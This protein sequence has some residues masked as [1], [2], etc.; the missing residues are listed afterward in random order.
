[1]DGSGS[2][3]KEKIEVCIDRGLRFL[4]EEQEADCSWENHPGI[5]ALAASAFLR[6]K[7]K[8]TD[9]KWE[10]SVNKALDYIANLSRPDG[11]IYKDDLASLNTAVCILT[12]SQSNS[13]KFR[14][15][16]EKAQQFLVRL[17]CDETAG[18]S[19]D[20][21]LY[22]GI[23]YGSDRTPDLDN[24]DYTLQ[25]LKSSGFPGNHDIWKKAVCFIQRCQNRNRSNDQDW[26]ADDG[27]FIYYPGFSMAGG[28][29]SYGSMTSAGI[30]CFL[31][32]KIKADD[33]R[34]ADAFKWL[35]GHYTLEE[36]PCV[37]QKGL[38][39]YYYTLSRALS[40]CGENII[41]DSHGTEHNW[42]EELVNKLSVLQ[43]KEGYW[44]NVCP[45]WWE[46]NKVLVTSYAILSLSYLY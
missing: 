7:T 10:S 40:R 22:G 43:H 26:S 21:R 45:E 8:H 2:I 25:A 32:A 13:H 39:H 4:L 23:R 41:K 29:R 12:L 1:M 46:G 11:G 24:L 5:T 34:V 36:N 16:I 9:L 28:T 14:S 15:I 37:G 27:G 33:P 20:D 19:R 44:L 17:Q 35:C 38:F 18:Y 31:N 42:S 30:S 6:G 3:I